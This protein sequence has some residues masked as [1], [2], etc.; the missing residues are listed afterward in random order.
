[1]GIALTTGYYQESF[2]ALLLFT[3]NFVAISAATAVTFLILGFRPTPAQKAR[4]EVQARSVRIALMMVLIVAILLTLFTYELA[5]EANYE[6]NMRALVMDSVTEITGGRIVSADDLI[7]VGEIADESVPLAMDLTV[8]STSSVPYAQVKE[9]QDAI[10]IGLQ[11]EV[12]LTMTVIRVTNLDPEVPPTFTPTPT[13]T[14]T[15]TPGPTPT[16]TA[17]ATPTPTATNT[18]TPL[19]TDTVTPPPTATPTVVPTDTAVPTPTPRTAVISSLYGLNLRAEPAADA[20]ILAFLSAD[21]TV[22]LLDGIETADNL[23]WQQIEVDGLVGW[24]SKQ[25]LTLP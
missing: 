6:A 19:P 20:D 18:A 17:T 12:G 22:I 24:V 9:L 25:F 15:F 4:R 11:R 23:S 5:Q 10:S 16:N 21:T 7:I 13:A 8:R 3:T 14:Q 1:V 2:G